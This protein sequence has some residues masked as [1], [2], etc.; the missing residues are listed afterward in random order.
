MCKSEIRKT[1]RSLTKENGMNVIALSIASGEKIPNLIYM[2]YFPFA[3][4]K[5]FQLKRICKALNIDLHQL[6]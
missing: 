5:L 2:M 3:N 4:I 6:I 1:L